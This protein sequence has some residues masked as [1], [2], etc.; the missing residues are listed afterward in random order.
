MVSSERTDK[1]VKRLMNILRT[2]TFSTL[3]FL[4]FLAGNLTGWMAR[5]VLATQ[6]P[7]TF[8]TEFDIFWEAWDVVVEHFVDRDKIDFH[9]MTYG[10]I[11]GMLNTLGDQNH[12]TFFPPETARLQANAL[13]GS[14]EGIGAH[15]SMEE[16]IFVIVAPIRGSP[17]E[18][19]GIQ[20]G[21][22]V[23]AVDGVPTTD[24]AEWEIIDRVRGPAGTTVTLTIL[25]PDAS[26]L[27]DIDVTRGR[28]ELE[29]V[30]WAPIPGT[31][32]VYIQ[33]SQFAA[34]TNFELINTLKEIQQHAETEPVQ[35]ILLD[36]RNNPGGYLLEAIRV[37]AQFLDEKAI[38]LHERDA[39]G[40]I[41]THRT[42]G[43]GYA[44]DLP[45]VV[46]VNEGSASAA[47]ILAGALQE[48]QR[49]QIVGATTLGT[50]TVL[51]QF[52]LSD[53]SVIRLGVTNWLTPDFHLIKNQGIQPNVPIA[54][55]ES[56]SLVDAM[57]LEQRMGESSWSTDDRQFNAALLLLRLKT[58][59]SAVEWMGE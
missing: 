50:G 40:N 6:E 29:S 27:I 34:D 12:T 35:G 5:P 57:T 51:Q 19:A 14:F 30:T 33:L 45:L 7:M 44:R 55:P 16:G 28:I 38:V 46:L 54:Q 32:L 3:L 41:T 53:G 23:I 17:A 56:I 25:H 15:V 52:T 26:E 13:E 49:A 2:V 31:N 10:A 36:L 43:N 24:M 47:E 8:P 1:L 42:R 39:E 21:D 37:A 48:N 22:R 58:I 59:N 18:A 11:E 4:T 9:R 20:A